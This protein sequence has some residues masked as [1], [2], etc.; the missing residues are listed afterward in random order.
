MYTRTAL[1]NEYRHMVDE[2]NHGTGIKAASLFCC[3]YAR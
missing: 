3:Y 1:R 2:N